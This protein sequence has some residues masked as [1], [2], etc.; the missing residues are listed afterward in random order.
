MVR[1]LKVNPVASFGLRAMG[2]FL[3]WVVLWWWASSWICMPVGWIGGGVLD[4]LLPTWIDSTHVAPGIWEVNTRIAIYD[5][6]VQR[7]GDV[8]VQAE[9]AR[10]AYGLPIALALLSAS[11]TLRTRRGWVF[12]FWAYLGLLPTQAL[13]LAAYVAMQIAMAAQMRLNTLGLAAWQLEVLA[14]AYQAGTLVLPTLVPVM[15]WLYLDWLFFADLMASN[16]RRASQ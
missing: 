8:V 16:H 15:V 1:G 5:P 12:G 11:G 14:F 13:S 3:V 6:Q 9:L 7:L 10:Y 2:W 4:L